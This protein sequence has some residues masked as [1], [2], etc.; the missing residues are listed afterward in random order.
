MTDTVRINVELTDTF[1]GE[2]NYCWVKRASFDV[3]ANGT[4]RQ[5]IRRAKALLGLSG[6]RHTKDSYGEGIVLNFPSHCMVAFLSYAT[7]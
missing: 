7:V 5:A 3:P 6:I 1:G 4:D 2:A